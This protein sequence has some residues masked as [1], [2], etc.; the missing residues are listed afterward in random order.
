M[1]AAISDQ[2]PISLHAYR[3]HSGCWQTKNPALPCIR[4][5]L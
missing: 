3:I 5:I 4:H 1:I 2:K